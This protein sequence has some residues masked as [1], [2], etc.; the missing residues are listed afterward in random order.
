[1]PSLAVGVGSEGDRGELE[2]VVR[3]GRQGLVGEDRAAV[4]L[5]DLSVGVDS[6]GDI[7][8]RALV[9][10]PHCEEG[11]L[12]QLLVDGLDEGRL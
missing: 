12:H 9:L 11:L 4:G 7:L 3:G 5:V 2:L 10:E 1:L 8:L 6:S